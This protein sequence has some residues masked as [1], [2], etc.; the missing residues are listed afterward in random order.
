MKQIEEAHKH[1]NARK[2]FKDI[3]SF[4]G[5]KP[6]GVLACRYEDEK[7]IFERKRI[8][9]RWEQFFS[10]LIKTDKKSEGNKGKEISE[11]DETILPPTTYIQTDNIITNLN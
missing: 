3:E 9:E 4:Q 5:G 6:I 1:N 8:L 11:V 10:T 2:F 7:L